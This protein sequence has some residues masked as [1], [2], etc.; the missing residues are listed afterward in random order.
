[1]GVSVRE[2]WMGGCVSEG[3]LDGWVCHWGEE[4]CFSFFVL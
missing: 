4:G 3:G 2:H 1:M